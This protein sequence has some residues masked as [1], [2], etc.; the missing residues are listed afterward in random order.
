[1]ARVS[2]AHVWKVKTRGIQL[3]AIDRC[4][5][6]HTV[7]LKLCPPQGPLCRSFI[8]K[9]PVTCI[10][11]KHKQKNY[12]KSLRLKKENAAEFDVVLFL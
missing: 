6:N 10:R 2:T 12:S 7:A 11:L 5:L 3:V 4:Q 1:M 8:S 9:P